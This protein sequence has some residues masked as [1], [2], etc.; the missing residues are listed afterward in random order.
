MIYP[1]GSGVDGHIFLS[2]SAP[3]IVNARFVRGILW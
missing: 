1:W 3:E 2:M